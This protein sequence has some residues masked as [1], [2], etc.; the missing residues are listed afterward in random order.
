MKMKGLSIKNINY[1]CLIYEFSFFTF[2]IIFFLILALISAGH[3]EVNFVMESYTIS[4]S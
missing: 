1:S 2:L 4:P 3:S